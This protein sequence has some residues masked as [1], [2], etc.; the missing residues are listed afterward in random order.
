M[1]HPLDIGAE[2]HRL[3]RRWDEITDRPAAPRSTMDVIEYGLGTQQRAEVYLNRLLCYLLDPAQPHQLGT[4]FLDAFLT[5]LPPTANFDED[6]YDLTDVRVSQQVPIWATR[7]DDRSDD[8]TPGYLDLFLDVPNEWFLSVELKF[9]APEEGTEFY[10]TAE[11][12]GDH[13]VEDYGSGQYYLYLHQEDRPEVSGECF[14]NWTWREFVEEVI[15]PFLAA[16]T[17]Q[18][19]QRTIV[20]LHD[21]R[22]DIRQ[23]AGMADQSKSD[24]EKVELYL[25]HAEAITDVTE[26]FDSE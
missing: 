3:H 17:P 14:V 23:I 20:Q 7:E 6:T 2:L 15:D 25:E 4:D 18:Y 5:R 10:C 16:N 8:A 26:T 12:I 19:P 9:A 13:P 22:D 1:A 24:Q 21:L 11:Q